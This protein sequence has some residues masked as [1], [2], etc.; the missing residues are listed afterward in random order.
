MRK[1][2]S[3]RAM[4]QRVRQVWRIVGQQWQWRVGRAGRATQPA[5][6]AAARELRPSPPLLSG[7][8]GRRWEYGMQM[9]QIV[10]HPRTE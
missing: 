10:L 5:G 4:A 6:R 1:S 7:P 8:A 2:L 3:M 9:R